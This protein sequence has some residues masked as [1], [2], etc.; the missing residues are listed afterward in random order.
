MNKALIGILIVF[1]VWF[2]FFRSTAVVLGPGVKA[3]NPPAQSKPTSLETR[4]V[5]GYTITNVADFNATAKVLGKRNYTFGRESDISPTDLALGWGNMSDEAVLQHI[6]IS[7]SRRFYF[8][9]VKQ[10]PI[11]R[12]EIETSSANM[13]IIPANPVVESELK[14]VR[15]GDIIQ[16]RGALV[17]VHADSG[18]W[19][20][21]SS[22]TR[23][24]TGNGACEIVWVEQ[25]FIVT[26]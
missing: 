5:E 17:N 23:N 16:M 21:N 4:Q 18:Q 13:H 19:W 9:R 11:P 25:L 26:P 22:K 15:E 6:N 20:W 3:P 1:I 10:F 14:R 7:Q 2:L 12:R 8:W 24:D